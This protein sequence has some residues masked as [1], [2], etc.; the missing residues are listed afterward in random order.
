M[1]ASS[2]LLEWPV[3]A[4]RGTHPTCMPTVFQ[5]DSRDGQG[6][7][8]ASATKTCHLKVYRKSWRSSCERIATKFKKFCWSRALT[9]TEV[10]RGARCVLSMDTPNCQ[11]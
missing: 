10:S 2:L 11:Y 6:I 5:R 8:K 3:V 9:Q 7:Q 1:S 4:T